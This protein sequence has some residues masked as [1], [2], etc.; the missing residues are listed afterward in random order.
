VVKSLD[1]AFSRPWRIWKYRFNAGI[2]V[3]NIFGSGGQ[4]DVQNNIASPAYGQFFNPL[5]RSIGFV[6]GVA[7]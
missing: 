3:Y 7:R 6:F 4:R 2:R 1:L 5:E